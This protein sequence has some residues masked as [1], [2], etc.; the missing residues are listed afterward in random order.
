MCAKTAW[1]SSRAR[2]RSREFSTT[3][4][5]GTGAFVGAY[6]LNRA[7][8]LAEGFDV[9]DDRVPRDPNLGPQ[10]EAQRRGG[11]VVDAALAW[12]HDVQQ[13]F[14]LWVHL[15][16]PHAPYDPPAEFLARAGGQAYDGEVAYADAQVGRV[17]AALRAKELLA[18][19]SSLSRVITAK[20]LGDHGEQSHGMLAYDSTLRVPLIVAGPGVA[21]SSHPWIAPVSLVQF[22]PKSPDDCARGRAELSPRR[23]C[24]PTGDRKSMPRHEPR[25]RPD[26]IS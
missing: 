19:P 16:D 6:V 4:A 2:R 12:L 14:F 11:E 21:G 5:T 3:P 7:F 20:R 15:Y 8:G 22:A 13:P 23:F 25:V 1:C 26:G 24:R 17:V 9:Y 10:L 18:K